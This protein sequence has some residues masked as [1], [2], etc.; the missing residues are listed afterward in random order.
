MSLAVKMGR[1]DKVFDVLVTILTLIHAYNCDVV[2]PYPQQVVF[3]AG[4]EAECPKISIIK[5][6][7]DRC[8]GTL[9]YVSENPFGSY[10]PLFRRPTNL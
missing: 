9:L 8:K 4:K 5:Q 7:N 2:P 6:K 10:G 1:V 3:Y